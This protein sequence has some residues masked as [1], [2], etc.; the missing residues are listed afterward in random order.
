MRNNEILKLME[1]IHMLI[2]IL[3]QLNLKYV[4]HFMWD[5]KYEFLR[6]IME[7]KIDERRR[8]RGNYFDCGILDNGLKYHWHLVVK[9]L[10]F[11]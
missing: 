11:I 6:T 9:I 3:K 8:L 5:S 10:W 1:T 7:G 2:K 4:R